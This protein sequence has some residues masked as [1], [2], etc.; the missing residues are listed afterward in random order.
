MYPQKLHAWKILTIYDAIVCS[1]FSFLVLGAVP[2]PVPVPV[3]GFSRSLDRRT[4]R[5]TDTH[6]H[7]Y[8]H[9]DTGKYIFFKNPQWILHFCLKL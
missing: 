3:P 8:T 9:A 1:S 7:T 4:E 2:V 6:T 5:Q